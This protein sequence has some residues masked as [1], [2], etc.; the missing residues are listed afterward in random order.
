MENI[1][2]RCNGTGCYTINICPVRH[3]ANHCLKS[4]VYKF[5]KLNKHEIEPEAI[6]QHHGITPKVKKLIQSLIFDYDISMP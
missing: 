2:L 6:K 1:L 4:N 3:K 5:C